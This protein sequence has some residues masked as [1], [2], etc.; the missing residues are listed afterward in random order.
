MSDIFT[1]INTLPR[2]TNAQLFIYATLRA[3]H[4]CGLASE[5][6]EP[7][8]WDGNTLYVLRTFME[9]H[10]FYDVPTDTYAWWQV[11]VIHQTWLTDTILFYRLVSSIAEH[12]QIAVWEYGE[13]LSWNTLPHNQLTWFYLSLL[14]GYDWKDLPF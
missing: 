4:A 8:Y 1:V 7:E 6:F 14:H 11:A 5:V 12:L 3:F 10:M 13:Q 9:T 2:T